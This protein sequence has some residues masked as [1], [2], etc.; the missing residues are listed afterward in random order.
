MKNLR[1]GKRWL[2][3]RLVADFRKGFGLP[4]PYWN[5]FILAQATKVTSP[6]R[7]Y[8]RWLYKDEKIRQLKI[9]MLELLSS[10]ESA[11]STA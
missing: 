6:T 7:A 9:E 10:H 8:P 3:R 5:A 11:M 1:R 4:E 2:F